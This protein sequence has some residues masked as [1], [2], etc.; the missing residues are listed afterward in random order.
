[1]V[2]VF[3]SSM[4]Y[5]GDYKLDITVK[6]GDKVFAPSW[7]IVMGYKNGKISADQ[8]IEAY[9]SIMHKSYVDNRKRWD[10]VLAMDEVVFC[11]YCKSG[12]FCH[13]LILSQ[14]FEKLGAKVFGEF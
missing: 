2:E 1:M 8:Y 6:S 12:D 7:D 14:I 10:E 11:C 13:R 4:Q 5:Q 3:T 9:L